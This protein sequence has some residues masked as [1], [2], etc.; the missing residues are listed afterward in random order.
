MKN[1]FKLNLKNFYDISITQNFDES[2]PNSFG[3]RFAKSQPYKVGDFEGDT[4]KGSSCNFDELSITPHCNGTHTESIGHILNSRDKITNLL[5]DIFTEALLIT[6]NFTKP[7]ESSEKYLPKIEANDL[8]ITA[9]ELKSKIGNEL[10]K[11]EGLI[12]RTLPNP[13][14]KKMRDYE[15]EPNGYFTNDAMQMIYELGVKHLLVDLP[16][17]DK[18][19]DEGMLSNHRIYWNVEIGKKEAKYNEHFHKTITEF[20]YVND[21]IEDGRYMVNLQ[22]APFGLD[23]SP[24][25]PILFKIE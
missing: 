25:R 3:V 22:I 21:E 6:C 1:K 8:L 24:S 14:S 5:D 10:L 12:I 18:A 23:A 9:K 15:K 17:I 16:S 19:N 2:Q 20:I 13:I 11:G 7:S 4:N